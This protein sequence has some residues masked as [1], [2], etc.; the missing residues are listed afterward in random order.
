MIRNLTP[1]EI[2]IMGDDGTVIARLPSEGVARA[3]QVD[4]AVDT[5]T[6]NGAAVPIVRTKYGAPVDLPAPVDGVYLIVSLLTANA[7]A[8]AGRPTHDLLLTSGAVRDNDGRIVGCR[9]FARL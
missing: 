2:T 6:I 8:A 5:V 9:Q 1:H 4:E 7:A 3:T